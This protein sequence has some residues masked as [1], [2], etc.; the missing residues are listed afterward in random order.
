M[1]GAAAIEVLLLL[2]LLRAVSAGLL[3]VSASLPPAAVPLEFWRCLLRRTADVA[4]LLS[5]SAATRLLLGLACLPKLHG[6][7]SSNCLRSAMR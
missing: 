4:R 3:A 6:T 2:V 5:P 7:P 1:V